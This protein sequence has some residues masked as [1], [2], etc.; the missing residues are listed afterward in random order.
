M[1]MSKHCVKKIQKLLEKL[2]DKLRIWTLFMKWS[3]LVYNAWE[4]L[5]VYF[6]NKLRFER[7]L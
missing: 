5:N 3:I 1:T 7:N 4:A 6:S 2:P